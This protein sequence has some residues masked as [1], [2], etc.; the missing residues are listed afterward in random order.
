MKKKII[1]ILVFL[2]AVIGT[3]PAEGVKGPKISVKEL[4]FDFGQV[5]QGKQV[6]H[7]FEILN[8][9]TEPLVIEKVQS[10]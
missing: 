8:E 9:G 10:G 6:S 3:A 5:A 2:V 1:P 7:V 4:R